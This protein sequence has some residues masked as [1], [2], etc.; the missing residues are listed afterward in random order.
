M[1]EEP[2]GGRGGISQDWVLLGSSSGIGKEMIIICP[3]VARDCQGIL[4]CPQVSTMHILVTFAQMPFQFRK[5]SRFGEK[6]LRVM[7]LTAVCGH[8]GRQDATLLSGYAHLPLYTCLP[9]YTHLSLHTCL[10]L[11]THL[12]SYTHLPLH[13]RLPLAPIR[14]GETPPPLSS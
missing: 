12:P 3:E 10:S 11:Y 1:K 2:L 13:T 14:E 9:L 8:T 6:R 4:A 7:V 5:M